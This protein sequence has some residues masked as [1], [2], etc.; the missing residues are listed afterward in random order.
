MNPFFF[1]DTT[2]DQN[3]GDFSGIAR[4]LPASVWGV[5]SLTNTSGQVSENLS[6]FLLFLVSCRVVEKYVVKKRDPQQL[7]GLLESLGNILILGARLKL[8]RGVV[9]P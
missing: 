3:L 2:E 4:G 5:R 1:N 7:T 9:R 8:A 6:T